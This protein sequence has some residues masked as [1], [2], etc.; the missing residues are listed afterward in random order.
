MEEK[1]LQPTG[2]FAPSPTGRMHLGNMLTALLSWLSARSRG[3]RWV[4]RIEDLDPQRSRLEYA[5]QIEDDLRWLGL[6]WDEGGLDCRGG[7][8]PYRQSLRSDI[9]AACLDRLNNLGITY[10]CRCTRAE[11]KAA[12]APHADDAAWIYP[13]TC[14]PAVIPS[15][16]GS[17]DFGGANVRLYVPD[18]EITVDDA[19]FGHRI[20]RPA[21]DF[22]DIV[23]RRADGAWS[24][25]LA[26]VADDA[27]MGI[28]EVV[29]GSD[30][31]SSAA[32]QIHIARL[33]G[34][35]PPRHIHVPL[36]CNAEGRR[37]SKR[38]SS[39]SME[40][41]RRAYSPRQL[42]GILGAA[43]GLIPE[44]EPTDLDT[45]LGLFDCKSIVRSERVCVSL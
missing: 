8:G 42:L 35:E 20:F 44:A 37:L 29:R 43:A 5:R 33:L 23:L 25:Q 1:T 22:G 15:P 36:L 21:R 10:P 28:N 31:L 24:Y 40:H 18:V 19:V 16:A 3:G 7:N 30:L 2:R 9:Y 13:G 6:Y 14:R 17:A 26:V 4:L 32:L 27:L 34:F 39:L 11:I 38:D 45:L 12:Q 41:L